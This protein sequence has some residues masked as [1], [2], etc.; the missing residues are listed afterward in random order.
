MELLPCIMKEPEGS[1]DA[2]VIWL[3][4]IGAWLDLTPA[5]D[6]DATP[7]KSGGPCPRSWAVPSPTGSPS[8]R[9]SCGRQFFGNKQ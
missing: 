2:A 6:T 3:N 7:I 1:A 9:S 8:A 4:G 5:E